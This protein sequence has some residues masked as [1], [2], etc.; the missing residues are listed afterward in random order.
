MLLDSEAVAVCWGHPAK[1][2][3]GELIVQAPV[4]CHSKGETPLGSQHLSSATPACSAISTTEMIRLPSSSRLPGEVYLGRCAAR[5]AEREAQLCP[6][7][8]GFQKTLCLGLMT[9]EDPAQQ[10]GPQGC[11]TWRI[12]E[13]PALNGRDKADGTGNLQLGGRTDGP[14]QGL[15]RR[16]QEGESS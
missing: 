14:S 11:F 5:E 4:G 6:G 9:C 1:S 13:P 10:A 16:E 7:A 2:S 15:S 12:H 3:V 8:S